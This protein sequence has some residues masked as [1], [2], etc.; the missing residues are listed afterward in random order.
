MEFIYIIIYIYIYLYFIY[1]IHEIAVW[2]S[3]LWSVV[4]TENMSHV[5]WPGT[6][7]F[8][9]A[10]LSHLFRQRN[11][12]I[13]TQAYAVDF[14]IPPRIFLS[15]LPVRRRWGIEQVGVIDEQSTLYL[16]WFTVWSRI[17]PFCSIPP[18]EDACMQNVQLSE[19]SG[20]CVLSKCRLA[21]DSWWSLQ[22]AP[23]SFSYLDLEHWIN[24]LNHSS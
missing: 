1:F 23:V 22:R 18:R 3:I 4:V 10:L 19:L 8:A 14:N 21:A 11:P 13:T 9:K 7:L 6:T 24:H 5:C 15:P 20:T 16:A 17:F 2:W 12:H